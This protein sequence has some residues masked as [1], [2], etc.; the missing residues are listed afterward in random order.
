MDLPIRAAGGEERDSSTGGGCGGG[1][2]GDERIQLPLEVP[3]H[4]SRAGGG[5]NNGEKGEEGGWRRDC[6]WRWRWLIGF[7]S[8]T[9]PHLRQLPIP[10]G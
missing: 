5:P 4:G 3:S 2:P 7:F 1:G 10:P 8:W 9:P 6:W